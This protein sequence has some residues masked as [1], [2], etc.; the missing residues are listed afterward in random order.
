MAGEDDNDDTDVFDADAAT[1][2]EKVEEPQPL[3]RVYSGSRIAI[4]RHVG[5]MWRQRLDAAVK[6][7]VE[8]NKVW[9]ELFKYYNNTQ[10]KAIDTPRGVFRRGDGVENVIFS[11]LN[12]ML[13]A[14][15]GKDPDVT[16]S[17]I[18]EEDQP[19]CDALEA[20]LNTLFRRRS[21][22]QAKPKIKKAVG[23]GLLTNL[24]VLK[25]DF[26]LKDDSRQLA[27]QEMTTLT[28]SLKDT[29]NAEDVE[30]IYG[31]IEALEMNLEVYKES[32]PGLSSLMPFNL[33]VDPYA[34]Q[35]DGLDATWM[36]EKTYILTS[37]LTAQFSQP[38]PENDDEESA[39]ANRV[40]VYKPTHKAVFAPDTTSGSRE[41]GLG[42]VMEALQHD[43]NEVGHH[44]ADERTAYLGMY[45]TECYLIWD[46]TTRRKYLFHR[47]DWKWPIWVWDDPLKLSRFFPYFLI[48]FSMNTGGT[49][50]V[51][52]T[53]YILDQQ[54]EINDINRQLSQIRRT[55][56]DYWYYN[57]DAV[58]EEAAESFTSALRGDGNPSAKKLLGVRAGEK[59]ISDMIE[60]VKPPSADYEKLFDKQ[61]IIESINRLTNTN[62]AL[63]GV[64][65]KTNTNVASVQSYQESLKL[66]VGA[67]VDVVEDT[68]SDVALA[69]AELCVQHYTKEDVEAIIGKVLAEGWQDMSLEM[70]NAQYNVD[71]VAG[72]M[73]KPNSVFK[74]KEAVEI[75]QAL[76]QFAKGAPGA[77]L[78]IALKVLSNAFTEVNIKKEDWLAIDQELAANMQAQQQGGMSGQPGQAPPGQVTQQQVMSLPPQIKM[79]IVQMHK[80]GAQP[81]QIQQFIQMALQQGGQQQQPQPGPQLPPQHQQQPAA[82]PGA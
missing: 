13:T 23:I 67:K 64:Q 38:D 78:R 3:F 74:K 24:G 56:F 46:K 14:V 11:N 71:I 80:A 52:E 31:Q 62:D 42:L 79:K 33:I 43:E 2:N 17:T 9:D 37:A 70:F 27:I 69:L 65:F 50:G 7:Y 34:E 12:I 66:S 29:E 81:Q 61:K 51:G 36:V 54:D 82:Q 18:D 8:V 19:F 4:S 63:R 59:K 58:D 73:E 15:Y 30:R 40:L 47:D 26:T 57:S 45:Y 10:N 35:P 68:V 76:G 75:V 5:K 49:V 32:G 22:L 44:Q 16:C 20:L 55:V 53:A 39:E 60:T 48:S 41:D 28:A 77:T 6:A 72:S 1:K 25:I 21:A